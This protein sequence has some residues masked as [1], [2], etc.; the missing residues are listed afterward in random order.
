MLKY[1][2]PIATTET[3]TN[4]GGFLGGLGYL[5]NKVGI[6]FMQTFE[7]AWDYAAGGI[8]DLF[9]ADE[10][11]RRQ[12]ENDWFGDWYYS[13]D[14]NFN[15][16]KGWKIAGD[17]A[18]G[19][20]NVTAG[21]SA[22]ALAVASAVGIA[23]ATGGTGL[24]VSAS[25]IGS[26]AAGIAA[27]LG[28]AGNATKEAYAKTGELTGK[29]YGYGA[30]VGATEGVIEGA[31]NMLAPGAGKVGKGL[32]K[33]IAGEAAENA[34]KTGL[35]KVLGTAVK[36][37]G[38]NFISEAVEEGTAEI[39]AP[40]YAK[41]TYDPNAENA[42]A[43]EVIYASFI[44]GLSG[45]L[46]GGGEAAI[47]G[48]SNSVANYRAGKK[49]VEA[50]Y[51]AE[52][53]GVA[54][55]I[56]EEEAKKPSGY[57]LFE[58]IRE[59]Y[60]R[61]GSGYGR[62]GALQRMTTA[63]H[64]LPAVEESAKAIVS[65]PEYSAARF[66]AIGAKNPDGTPLEIT[67][68]KLTEGFDRNAGSETALHS[69]RRALST[70]P[71]LLTLSV[72]DATGK[73]MLDAENY[74]G[75][76]T[77]GGVLTTR[78]DYQTFLAK[79]SDEQ[80]AAVAQ[81]FGL[82]ATLDA[83]PYEDMVNI[84][85]GYAATP[86]GRAAIEAVG[87]VRYRAEQIEKNEKPLPKVVG[88]ALADGIYRYGDVA[89]IKEGGSVRIYDYDTR[90]ITMAMTPKEATAALQ[91]YRREQDTAK[92]EERRAK[93]E[94]QR[95][96]REEELDTWAREH[97]KRYRELVGNEQREIRTLIRQ[98]RALGLSDADI[99]TYATVSS[100][101]S[102]RV[103]FSKAQC[104]RENVEMKDGKPV[105][106]VGYA[107][108]FYSPETNEIVVNPEG[109][110][111]AAKLLMHELSHALYKDRRFAEVIDGEV[112]HMDEKRKQE[113]RE[114]YE[115]AGKSEAE[116]SEDLSVHHAEDV[117]ANR[118]NLAR[119]MKEEPTLGDKILSFFKL[120]K[121]DYKGHNRLSLAAGRLYRT[122]ETILA[123][124][125]EFNRGNL[126][127]EGNP[128]AMRE[129][130]AD[131]RFA[132]QFSDK[133]AEGQRA[134]LASHQGVIED[135]ELSKAIEDTAKMVK[136]ML[137]H[138][139]ILPTDTVG[140]KGATLVKNGSYD[141][142]VENTTVCIRTLSYNAFTDMVSEKIGRPL[143]Q[144]ESFLVSQKLYDIAKEPQCLYCYV[145]LDRKAF[146]E[147]IIRY[148][149]QR[150]AA[151]KAWEEAGK[152]SVSRSSELYEK[153]RAGRKDTD[154][155]WKRYNE[156]ISAAKSGDKLITLADVAT[157]SR[158]AD[159]AHNG[160][161][162]QKAQIADML[163]YA[164]SASWAK[165]QT[166][167]V[168]YYD[169]I[170]RLSPKAVKDL[171]KH[172]GL[173]WYS[174]S[175]YSGAFIVENMQQVTDASLR[176]LKGLS[177]TKD[178]DFARI[179]APTG[180]NI[181]ISVYATDINGKWEIDPKQSADIDAAIK[182]REQYPNVGIVVVAAKREG[183][184][185]ALAQ[186]WS[187]VV[188]PFHIVRSGQDV[189]NFYDWEVFNS[190][191][192]DTVMDENLWAQYVESL[193]NPKKVSKSIYPSEHQNS[194]ETYLDL[195]KSRGIKPRFS[196]F[197]DN[198]NYMKLVNETRQREADTMPLRPAFDL[199]AA[200][201]SFD[202]FV[203]KGGYYEGWY[204][205]G[206]DISAEVD[207]VAADV[208]AGKKANEVSYGRQDKQGNP[209]PTP[210]E[211]MASRK[212]NRSHGRRDALP[213]DLDTFDISSYNEIK[214]N[215]IE[216]G[217]LQSE[218]ITWDANHRNEIRSRTLSNGVHYRYYI[219]DDGLVHCIGRKQSQNIHEDR[220]EYRDRNKEQL[221]SL[222]K[223][224]RDG[225]G[226]N[227]G[228]RGTVRD[229]RKSADGDRLDHR[230]LRQARDD[231]R[232]DD[233]A[234][235]AVSD[236]NA[237][238]LEQAGVNAEIARALAFKERLLS[239]GYYEENGYIYAPDGT[240]TTFFFPEVERRDALPADFNASE[241]VDRG[242]PV[243]G[244]AMS[245]G[246]AEK[247]RANL[248]RD[249]VYSAKEAMEVVKSIPGIGELGGREVAKIGDAVWSALN[250]CQSPEQR[251]GVADKIARY[252][253]ARMYLESEVESPDAAAA[254]ER[255]SYYRM[256][257]GGLT[258]SK[259]D[260]AEIRHTED[261]DGLRRLIGRWGYK[262]RSRVKTPMDVFVADVARAMPGM[263][264]LEDM[265]PVEAFLEINSLYESAVQTAGEKVSAYED[266]PPE[267]VQMSIDGIRET[268]LRAFDEKGDRS[269]FARIMEDEVGLYKRALSQTTLR[270]R[271]VDKARKLRDI[272]TG[273]FANAT[274]VQNDTFKTALS[275]LARMNYRG[276]LLRSSARE[277]LGKL[278][279]WYAGA[280]ETILLYESEE[281][282][283]PY[284]S[285][286]VE[287][288]LRE[289]ADGQYDFS[290]EELQTLE[291]LFDY[292][293]WLAERYDKVYNKATKN[294]E[295]VKDI[296][297]S[298][299]G[300]IRSNQKVR[301]RLFG[302]LNEGLYSETFHDPMSVARRMDMYAEDG[303]YTK[304][305]QD[306]REST[307]QAQV[308]EMNIR[309]PLDAFLSENKQYLEKARL[310]K[311]SYRDQEIPRI[312]LIG[313]Y[314]TY[315]R[316]QAWRG[317]AVNGFVYEDNDGNRTTVR[318]TLQ[319][320][321]KNRK[322]DEAALK[323][324]VESRQKEIEALLTDADREYIGILEEIYNEKA[325][326]LKAER[327]YQRRGISNVQ[328]GYYYPIRRYA[329]K[330]K[331]IDETS[332][333]AEI[334]RISNASFNK[335]TVKGAS[336]AL[337]IDPA[338][339]VLERHLPAVCNYAFITPVLDYFNTVYNYDVSGNA[340]LP[341]SVRTVSE[342]YWKNG[343]KYLADLFA[344]AQGV[345]S[346]GSLSDKA[347]NKA[348]STLRGSYAKAQLG[349][350]P[351]VWFTQL[352]SFFSA[353]SILDYAS[354]MRGMT[355]SSRDVDKYCPLAE[356]RSY[357]NS[358]AMAQAVTDRKIGKAKQKVDKIGD[359]LM[360]PIGKMD[361]FVIGRL[362]GACQVQVE[363]DGGAKVGTDENKVEAGKLLQRVILETQQNSLATERSSAMRS[364]SEMLRML[365]MFTSDAMK[366]A[367]RVIDGYGEVSILRAKIK[368]ETDAKAKAAL[369]EQMKVAKRKARKALAA[370]AMQAAFM[371][372]I[373]Q[374]FRFLYAKEEEEPRSETMLVD[375]VGNLLGGLPIISDVYSFFFEGYEI[376]DAN[377]SA[378]ND[379]LN[380]VKG[381][382]N[383][384]ADI[385]K[386]ES[387]PTARNRAFRNL[388]YSLGQ[389]TGLP[390]RNIY[391]VFYGLTKRIFPT[392]AYSVDGMFYGNSY[393]A[394]LAKAIEKGDDKMSAHIFGLILEEKV[395]EEVDSAVFNELLSLAKQGYKVLPK[396]VRDTVTVDGEEYELTD[397]QVAAIRQDYTKA[398][399]SIGRLVRLKA[400][401]G[402]DGEARKDVLKRAYAYTYEL[403]EGR[404][405]GTEVSRAAVISQLAG[406][407]LVALFMH[408]TKD[409]ESD[410]DKRGN[411]IEGSLRRKV[412]AAVN[413]LN[414]PKEQKLIL[415]YSR[416]YSAKDGDIKGVSAARA[417]TV[418][419][420]YIAK[421]KGLTKAQREE[422]AK[423]C[424]FTVKD[425]KIV[426]A[427]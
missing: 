209:I 287:E 215:G 80:K 74:A 41:L 302:K 104:R 201:K 427:K 93:A 354:V 327:D 338:D 142:S 360:T 340:N 352:S 251:Y 19:I 414:I 168:A 315:K 82:T 257:I 136:K 346:A 119:M 359:A 233:T 183:V 33:A 105:I 384:A 61:P 343:Y 361:R 140:K 306:L 220:S 120:A 102:V 404:V 63:S 260:L 236:G 304:I 58:K 376:E 345:R 107:D 293:L 366:A 165:K 50:G 282:P 330:A 42:T 325:K 270:N 355:V 256:G 312:V 89:I 137:P 162:S 421:A 222:T 258:F 243:Q 75:L 380:S 388:A 268:I 255:L 317:L 364:Q 401:Q 23:A 262:G 96:A 52:I 78:G 204:N 399:S 135:S 336:Q 91:K 51:T 117:V 161:A 274:Q 113:V 64:Y 208:L 389:V 154:N 205:D 322:A 396:T 68:E 339:S 146:N 232:A 418:L 410:L 275:E 115:K 124:F 365:T 253:T 180:M 329:T 279:A 21:V 348:L 397:E 226:D 17:V 367:G 127:A 288:A 99:E 27:G 423:A 381:I 377:Y 24:P 95:K 143:S 307:I 417:K 66:L 76:L 269:R 375:F 125:S 34:A 328:D 26:T 173:R 197:L 37:A 10:W 398:Q 18:G 303:F 12:M 158:R 281:N 191:Q 129:T 145:S 357:E 38:T 298:T 114:L 31:S 415:L 387:D 49:A 390:V 227:R 94:E 59:V 296:A 237:Q 242:L 383:V 210:A 87:N 202:R 373:A 218:A 341:V 101:S 62:I 212:A 88:E 400:Y 118:D 402:L 231:K 126:A 65:N 151:V 213:E 32:Y 1:K 177:Y 247:M 289:L 121:T 15:P 301:V 155:M 16:G 291:N 72:A 176:G 267:A 342:E 196:S 156:W 363:R 241:V 6:G 73:M 409:L 259:Q 194:R 223:G 195:C 81:H 166:K 290:T 44:G 319:L 426:T 372:G 299:I 54:K 97:I 246:Q 36:H 216:A 152:P 157:E 412:V 277:H 240:K 190:E 347:V 46:A 186:E 254:R 351:K 141:V 20:G 160:T 67:P 192:G 77:G 284:Y 305:L 11:A 138:K 55:R 110:R 321:G 230:V 159:I 263:E 353:T 405:L 314:M 350:N 47:L 239:K 22:A 320:D 150:D 4:N 248:Y 57:A 362:F 244:A 250:A 252:I 316:E 103:T 368:G 356:L 164:Q 2:S 187:D 170:L 379:V 419:A 264:Y 318:G 109:K 134:Y 219:D 324:Y 214:L 335:D 174:F 229:G 35:S 278:A 171:N 98:G 172:Y 349:A 133:I 90:S 392:A 199:G 382:S 313:L 411:V 358:A 25:V 261:T 323:S 45:V 153:F 147:M 422:L 3:P 207:I 228:I 295:S 182:L 217:R 79:A 29:E 116:I 403:S 86:E 106:L 203:E 163:K 406:V 234:N 272:K 60:E 70:N 189:A 181:N 5:G 100:R 371:V 130:M 310:E 273:K 285:S 188:I 179:F 7:G 332:I 69:L 128:M 123:S 112:K 132:L 144:M 294:W 378:I 200:E 331:S 221:D 43:E 424:G 167:Y 235:G 249:K 395:D 193:G 408:M 300:T 185:W 169:D 337:V 111:S 13:A 394:D 83:I 420:A 238:G 334:D 71:L 271:L 48:T 85:T 40:Q 416:G 385:A 283:G 292:F 84:A 280:K 333:Q 131:A 149:E 286:A 391:N 370:I 184:E 413:A 9:G 8:A 178:V 198:P 311:V 39:L 369:S 425:G 276:N 245:V 92:A 30:L 225:H 108:G 297:E 14:K 206:V 308:E 211:L 407:D 56:A 122:F 266:A 265:P 175:D 53:E 309:R 148:T 224:L 393:E 344:D 28:A 386:G 139:D 326:R 374:L